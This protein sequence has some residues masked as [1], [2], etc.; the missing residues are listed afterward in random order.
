MIVVG[1]V[2]DFELFN[3]NYFIEKKLQFK[4]FKRSILKT[5]S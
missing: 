2:L 5:T 4:N 3:P 1:F